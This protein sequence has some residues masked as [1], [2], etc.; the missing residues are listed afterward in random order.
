MAPEC[1]EVYLRWNLEF[2]LENLNP[3]K[4]L[5]DLPSKK[6]KIGIKVIKKIH[7]QNHV[8]NN[9]SN[10]RSLEV[11]DVISQKKNELHNF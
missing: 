5:L 9:L 1:V 7:N 3:L 6:E 10:Y 4:P 8:G 2:Y 11:Y